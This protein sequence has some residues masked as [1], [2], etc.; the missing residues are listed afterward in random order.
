MTTERTHRLRVPTWDALDP[1]VQS[2]VLRV[3]ELHARSGKASDEARAASERVAEVLRA[4]EKRRSDAIA[5]GQDDPG[6]DQRK[7]N[8]AE[9]AAEEAAERSRLTAAALVEASRRLEVVCADRAEPWEAAAR[10]QLENA[11]AD[12]ADAV[13][14]V[15]RSYAAWIDARGQVALATDERPRRRAKTGALNLPLQVRTEAGGLRAMEAMDALA[16]LVET[17]QREVA[18]EA[19]P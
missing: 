3:R 14:A 18:D 1:E 2:A 7:I 13:E 4:D 8:A 5:D 19:D 12:L 15:R 6:R 9:K 11:A 17:P 16:R 10:A